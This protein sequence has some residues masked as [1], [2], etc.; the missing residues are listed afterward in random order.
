MDRKR[1]TSNPRGAQYAKI[2]ADHSQRPRSASVE[3]WRERHRP[4]SAQRGSSIDQ[5]G[6]RN[7][8]FS[9]LLS[10][11]KS[12]KVGGTLGSCRSTHPWR[13]R[14]YRSSNVTANSA[15]FHFSRRSSIETGFDQNSASP[16]REPV[17]RSFI[18][19]GWPINSAWQPD[20]CGEIRHKGTRHK[21]RHPPIVE[22][23]VWDKN[24]EILHADAAC[25]RGKT[26]KSMSSPL[27]SKLFDES[28]DGLTPSHSVTRFTPL[29]LLRLPQPYEGV[30]ESPRKRLCGFRPPKS[31]TAWFSMIAPP[32]WPTSSSSARMQLR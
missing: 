1:W 15:A 18:F 5:Q 23:Q 21:G 12:A 3:R 28:W 2:I 10:V 6:R 27:A 30:S 14:S 11:R 32:F 13:K 17:R 9:G 4:G 7:L 25:A 20:L 8:S 22:R 24:D 19:A 16:K 31:S 29:S 26:S